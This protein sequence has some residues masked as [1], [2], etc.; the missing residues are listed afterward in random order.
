MDVAL[1]V[2]A[3]WEDT[4]EVFMRDPEQIPDHFMK[5]EL[6]QFFMD[7]PNDAAFPRFNLLKGKTGRQLE[8]VSSMHGRFRNLVRGK[9]TAKLG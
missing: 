1:N 2:A 3:F 7:A 4:G 9:S 5:K 6:K 8:G